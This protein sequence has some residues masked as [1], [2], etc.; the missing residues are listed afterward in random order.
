MKPEHL[1]AASQ[2]ALELQMLKALTRDKSINNA[3]CGLVISE[4]L[5]KLHC[6]MIDTPPTAVT[7]HEAQ[8]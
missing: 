3:A 5:A 7:A 2:T 4:A 8:A 6:T 1:L